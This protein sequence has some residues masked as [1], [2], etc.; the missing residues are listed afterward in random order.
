VPVS[1]EGLSL[2][3]DGHSPSFTAPPEEQ[4]VC[5]KSMLCYTVKSPDARSCTEAGDAGKPSHA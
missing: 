5:C 2:V 4:S 3:C 1:I